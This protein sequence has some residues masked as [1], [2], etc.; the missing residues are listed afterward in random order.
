MIP[1]GVLVLVF[2]IPGCRS[3]KEKRGL[4]KPLLSDLHRKFDV[5]VAE[6][7]FQ[8]AWQETAIACALVG[9]DRVVVERSLQVIPG[10]CETTHRSLQLIR[11]ELEIL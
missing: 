10:Y 8:D 1:L 5:S 2:R 3:L 6:V 7:D 4:L 11:Q 9:S